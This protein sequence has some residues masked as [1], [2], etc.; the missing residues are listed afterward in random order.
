MMPR[1]WSSAGHPLVVETAFGA[2]MSQSG[3]ENHANRLVGYACLAIE[4]HLTCSNCFEIDEV[5]YGLSR[6]REPQL[7]RLLYLVKRRL[8]I[9]G[10]ARDKILLCFSLTLS[11]V[12]YAISPIMDHRGATHRREDVRQKSGNA[13]GR[14]NY[15]H[16]ISVVPTSS[17]PDTSAVLHN[18]SW[19]AFSKFSKYYC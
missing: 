6:N 2:N 5:Q 18:D 11:S 16:Y 10:S 15:N 17:R 4:G 8:E 7:T 12:S 1:R 13:D 3:Y 19:R 9:T 14:W